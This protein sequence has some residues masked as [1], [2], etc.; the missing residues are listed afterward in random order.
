M[1]DSVRMNYVKTIVT[2][3]AK[4]AIAGLGYIAEMSNVAWNNLVRNFGKP[5]M[6]VNAQ[7]KRIYSFPPMK[8]YDGEHSSSMR[9]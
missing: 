6:I 2:G 5:Q 8:P 3:K 4:V 1:D 9:E 7:L